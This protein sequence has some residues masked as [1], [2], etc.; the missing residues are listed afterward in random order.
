MISERIIFVS[1]GITV[2]A[3]PGAK[4]TRHTTVK[5]ICHTWGAATLPNLQFGVPV[6]NSFYTL[7]HA[8]RDLILLRQ[9]ERTALAVSVLQT[10][11]AGNILFIALSF[12]KLQTVCMC[13]RS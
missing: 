13:R 3:P 12:V 10:P 2:L 1:R 9:P 4:K 11:G 6:S 7:Q 5:P 8:V